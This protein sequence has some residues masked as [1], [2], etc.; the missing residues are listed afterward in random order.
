[1]K[2]KYKLIAID[3]DGTLLND[4][5]KKISCR[6][7]QAIK[8]CLDNGVKVIISSGRALENIHHYM[9][10][11]GIVESYGSAF[12]G[13]TIFKSDDLEIVNE[14]FLDNNLAKELL[15]KFEKVE[16]VGLLAYTQKGLYTT[17]LNNHIN[18]YYKFV[19]DISIIV[20]DD[21][22]SIEE[23]ISKILIKGER[24]YLEK[25][26]EE[27]LEYNDRCRVLFSE[28]ELL[29]FMS[30]ETNKGYSLEKIAGFHNIDIKDTIA[31]GDNYND[32]E[33]I[34]KAGIGVAVYNAVD[35]LKVK[36][37]YVTINDNNKDAIYE[38]VD[39]YF[40]F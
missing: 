18:E 33:M 24:I 31:I 3:L 32:I 37:D 5:D 40:D 6:N 1:M 23:P 22:L 10:E 19:K 35:A 20:V 7:K 25:I 30:L 16:N 13:S 15:S 8:K 39:R 36:A 38:V 27:F 34:E 12:H 21:L 29:E 26:R 4:E 2:N 9:K 11:L 28:T 17:D 14:T